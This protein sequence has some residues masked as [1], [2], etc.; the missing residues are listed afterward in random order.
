MGYKNKTDLQFFEEMFKNFTS[1]NTEVSSFRN[2]QKQHTFKS[3]LHCVTT[4]N[5]E[6]QNEPT[7]EA[8]EVLD[9]IDE[10][11]VAEDSLLK[12][13]EKYFD[14]LRELELLDGQKT[15]LASDEWQE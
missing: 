14:N 7:L 3:L 9:L 10:Y 13:Q 8:K 4:Q 5:L 1:S 2:A 11:F 12:L 15:L 6:Y